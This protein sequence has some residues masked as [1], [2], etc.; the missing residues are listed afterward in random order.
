[1]F[2]D[3]VG[4]TEL[5]VRLGHDRY[6]SVLHLHDALIR[7]H[8]EHLGGTV[9]KHTGDGCMAVFDVAADALNA[10]RLIQGGL[11]E[12]D[13]GVDVDLKV[14]IGV[15][16]GDVVK[17]AGD[18]HGIAAVEAARLCSV[19]E[20]E[21]VLLSAMTGSLVDPA[22]R[23]DLV[24]IGT[25]DLKGLP[26]VPAAAFRW[27]D[28]APVAPPTHG[29]GGRLPSCTD[30]FFGRDSEL[31]ELR[32]HLQDQRLVTLVGPGGSGKTRLALEVATSIEV[33]HRRTN[34]VDLSTTE[35]D[36]IVAATVVAALG[37]R[38]HG[39]PLVAL[40][41]HLVTGEA[42]LVLDNCEHVLVGAAQLAFEL[43][44][45]C[46]GLR[47][48]ATSREPL[49]LPGE[50]EYVIGPLP[51]RSAVDLFVDRCRRPHRFSDDD[52]DAIRRICAAVEGIPLAIELAA[53]RLRVYSPAELAADVDD[54]LS[55]LIE[56]G[57]G[58]PDRHRTLRS[59]LDW[60]H[61]LLDDVERSAFR[62]LAVFV[63]GFTMPAARAV[64]AGD[65][66]DGAS[67]VD[68]LE[69]LATK[70]LVAE[71][72]A[73]GGIRLRLLEPIRQYAQDR[74]EAAEELDLVSRRQL[75]WVT[76]MARGIASEYSSAP[77]VALRQERSEHANIVRAIDWAIQHGDAESAARVII[78]LGDV[79]FSIGQPD[80]LHW[81]TL[82]LGALPHDVRPS[83]RAGV[84]VVAGMMH[85]DR[86][87]YEHSVPLLMEALDLYQADCNPKREAWTLTWLG[88]AA[89]AID[90]DGRPATAWIT[91]A[92]SIYE[93]ERLEA[94]V[95]WCSA[96]LAGDA[97]ARDE[98]HVARGHAERA[99]ALGRELGLHQA[100]G[101]GLRIQ[102]FLEERAGRSASADE[103]SSELLATSRGAEDPWQLSSGLCAVAQIAASRGDVATAASHALASCDLAMRLESPERLL[104][105]ISTAAVVAHAVGLDDV[106]H[107][108]LSHWMNAEEI[109][110]AQ[111]GGQFD[112]LRETRRSITVRSSTP[113]VAIDDGVELGRTILSRMLRDGAT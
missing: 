82:A 101:E 80:A 78:R 106:V 111:L 86:L 45:G 26:P 29:T 21:Q 50:L 35:G 3:I 77:D 42:L 8:V 52:L 83:S 18:Y 79:W 68:A 65:D 22:L 32:G 55:L 81:C 13:P 97:Y 53:A 75:R 9:V 25:L 40:K 91:E 6:L 5:L 84:L 19:A 27:A 17:V 28:D 38:G 47:L 34:F 23:H 41:E 1:M 60:S 98:L 71:M 70:S 108:L 66:L 104:E 109:D 69:S 92:L 56:R 110:R 67:V 11:R 20:P 49:G 95:A 105:F 73:E 72:S 10:A 103:L 37:L 4:S 76:G 94:G 102:M 61:D 89:W 43:L 48:L 46:P 51:P 93:R 14:R 87:E 57:R 39:D 54:L 15:S 59:T 64:V 36:E 74:L 99:A 88:R 100:L 58:R 112:A 7:N 12:V 96:L 90:V 33:A 85:Q 113:A 31:A 44:A 24:E 62:R 2:T 107:R 16:A 30:R 63:G